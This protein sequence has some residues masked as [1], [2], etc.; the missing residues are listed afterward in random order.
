MQSAV[1]C[2]SQT[3]YKAKK[4]RN[5]RD[6]YV[7]NSLGKGIPG[8]FITFADDTQLG[9]VANT[10]EEEKKIQKHPGCLDHWHL[11]IYL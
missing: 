8:T 6:K 9:E 4:L 2:S 11:K 3:S 7:I 1:Y 10:L 5:N